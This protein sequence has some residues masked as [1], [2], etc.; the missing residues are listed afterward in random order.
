MLGIVRQ[1][2]TSVKGSDRI[3]L[4]VQPLKHRRKGTN[5]ISSFRHDQAIWHRVGIHDLVGR[6][7]PFQ[8][9][10]LHQQSRLR[11]DGQNLFDPQG[12][13]AYILAPKKGLLII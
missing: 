8:A 12:E 4:T 6:M 9:G 1:I 3:F 13:I 11:R 7:P 10:E 5:N 2:A